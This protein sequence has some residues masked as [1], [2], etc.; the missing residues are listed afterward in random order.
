MLTNVVKTPV[1]GFI[2]FVREQGVVGLAIGFI[3][4]GAINKV[5]GS[6]VQDIIQPAIGF[7]FG[8]PEG[9]AGLQYH[10]LKYGQFIANVIDFLILAGVVYFVFKHMRLDRIDAPKQPK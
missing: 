5:V 1:R 9:L 6:L 3:L 10:S 4:G 7:F 2:Q 8:K